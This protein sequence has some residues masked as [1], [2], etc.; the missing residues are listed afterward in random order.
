MYFGTSLYTNF[1][2]GL[3]VP[4]GFSL[5]RVSEIF[6]WFVNECCQ[7]G[8]Q[9]SISLKWQNPEFTCWSILDSA[10]RTPARNVTTCLLIVACLLLN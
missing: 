6:H 4:I 7:I 9:I 10:V 8:T 2:S 3:Q 5:L 1:A